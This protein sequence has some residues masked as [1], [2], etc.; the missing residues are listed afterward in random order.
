M[1]GSVPSCSLAGCVHGGH[2]Q[3]L[4]RRLHVSISDMGA[5]VSVVSVS[6]YLLTTYYQD[7]TSYDLDPVV[8]AATGLV[9]HFLWYFI[10]NIFFDLR[11]DIRYGSVSRMNY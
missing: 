3:L 1:L 10:K 8:P 2:H 4:H 9:F 11:R 7:S 5:S 6:R